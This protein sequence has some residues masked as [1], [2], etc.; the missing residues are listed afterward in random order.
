[1]LPE[2]ATEISRASRHITHT[3]ADIHIL[4]LSGCCSQQEELLNVSNCEG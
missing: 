1:L 3:H 2:L 4:C